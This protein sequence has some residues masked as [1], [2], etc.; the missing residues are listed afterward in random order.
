MASV[1]LV[2]CFRCRHVAFIVKEEVLLRQVLEAAACIATV[3][4]Q[5][6]A[7]QSARPDVGSDIQSDGWDRCSPNVML[8]GQDWCGHGK[9]SGTGQRDASIA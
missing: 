8:P 6:N 5:A 1:T 9:C 7:L 4:S 3:S 2:G